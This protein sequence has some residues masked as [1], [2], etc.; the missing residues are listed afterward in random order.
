M[1]RRKMR[2]T[3]YRLYASHVMRNVLLYK[4]ENDEGDVLSFASDVE[5]GILDT[6]KRRCRELKVSDTVYMY[7][8]RIILL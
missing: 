1:H 5:D 8:E 7:L 3:Y 4:H 6:S 2:V